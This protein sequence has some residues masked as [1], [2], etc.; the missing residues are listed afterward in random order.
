M[1]NWRSLAEDG[2]PPV[3]KVCAYGVD[4]RTDDPSITKPWSK[5]DKVHIV[6]YRDGYAVIYNDEKNNCDERNLDYGDEGPLVVALDEAVNDAPDWDS[7]PKDAT[8]WEP[9]NDE[10]CESWMKKDGDIWFYFSPKFKIWVKSDD[11]AVRRIKLMIHRPQVEPKEWNGEGLPPVGTVCDVR[12]PKNKFSCFS[13]W[14]QCTYLLTN[15]DKLGKKQHVIKD[16]HGNVAIF[17]EESGVEFRPIR[18]EEDRAVEEIAK[19]LQNDHQ[20]VTD[21]YSKN[22]DYFTGPAR[23]LYRHGYRKQE[24]K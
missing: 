17:Y 4:D 8:H 15:I 7:A 14:S 13:T 23:A 10:Y 6:G 22:L 2:H 19:I 5:G 18:S 20:L 21:T 12:E 9:E 1:K 11:I 16:H 3:G 24:K